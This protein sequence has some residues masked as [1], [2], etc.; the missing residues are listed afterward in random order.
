MLKTLIKPVLIL[1]VMAGL[2]ACTERINIDLKKGD[3]HLIVEGY[4]FQ[5][6][7]TSWVRLTK[8]AAYFSEQPPDAVQ[9]A[10]V[11]I[12]SD[13]FQF[14]MQEQPGKPGYYHS[15]GTLNPP[16]G[17][18]YTLTIDLKQPIGGHSHYEATAKLLPQA[19]V[20]DSVKILLAPH[21]KRWIV[22]IYGQDTPETNFYLVNSE[23]NGRLLTDTLSRKNVFDD[24]LFNNSYLPGFVVQVLYAKEVVPGGTYTLILSNITRDY[25]Q[26]ISDVQEEIRPKDPLFSGPPA[27]VPSNI[28]GDALGFFA[29]YPSTSYSITV[30]KPEPGGK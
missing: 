8:S 10:I 1:L 25:Y 20:I 7:S 2:N 12:R 27:N 3:I 4:L 30:P 6:D 11:S 19:M 17:T 23:F 26:Y 16:S 22:R 28:S 24:R 5:G 29:A 13:L 14:P 9:G 18:T 21:F 15:M